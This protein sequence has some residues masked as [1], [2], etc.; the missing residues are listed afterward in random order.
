MLQKFKVSALCF[1]AEEIETPDNQ[2]HM[3]TY[4]EKQS[5]IVTAPSCDIA[6]AIVLG[7][8]TETYSER[9]KYLLVKNTY[10]QPVEDE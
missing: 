6:T 4:P 5:A 2:P 7:A 1:V 8:L 9:G 3:G 10:V